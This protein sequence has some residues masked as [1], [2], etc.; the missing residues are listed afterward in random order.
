MAVLRYSIVYRILGMCLYTLQLSAVIVQASNLRQRRY[1]VLRGYKMDHVVAGPTSPL[2][3]IGCCS[4]CLETAGC[5]AV[6]YNTATQSCELSSKTVHGDNLTFSQS[7]EWDIYYT[8]IDDWSLVFRAAAGNGESVYDTW[9]NTT[10]QTDHAG[11]C[12][13]LQ[14]QPRCSGHYKNQI[15]DGW[16]N[17]DITQVKLELHSAGRRVAYVIFDGTGSDYSNWFSKDRILESS[18]SD[19]T[20]SAY[21]TSFAMEGWEHRTVLIF[22]GYGTCTTDVAW[23]S[24]VAFQGF[25]SWDVQSSYPAFVFSPE[26]LQALL[27]LV[28]E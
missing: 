15:V 18:W 24:V 26:L 25:C 14:P 22:Q 19:L 7:E 5:L 10:T 3:A 28:S 11:A 13:I 1:K 23:M 16:N 6:N 21:Y 2:S 8:L 20:P 4:L 17:A 27:K 9:I 12:Q